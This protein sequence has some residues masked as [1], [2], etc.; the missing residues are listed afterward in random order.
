[1][2]PDEIARALLK[3][4]S[5]VEILNCFA[6]E[7][8]DL[9]EPPK[10]SD[11]YSVTS[12]ETESILFADYSYGKSEH[13]FSPESNE[14]PKLMDGD[15]HPLIN[16]KSRWNPCSDPVRRLQSDLFSIFRQERLS[17]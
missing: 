3:N 6:D 17:D 7:S 16:W 15:P 9:Y 11:E 2:N 4:D 10:L 8:D 12:D 5:D 13:N 1:M 14:P